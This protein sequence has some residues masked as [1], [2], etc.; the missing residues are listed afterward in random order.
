[1]ASTGS[2]PPKVPRDAVA[3][4]SPRPSLESTSKTRGSS[5]QGAI[6]Y[7]FVLLFSFFLL[8][9]PED[10][11]IPIRGIKF[12][13]IFGSA[14]I[15]TWALGAAS[16]QIKFRPSRELNLVLAL[17]AWLILGV[18]F[19]YWPSN[20]LSLLINDWVKI[21]MIFVVLTQTVTSTKRLRQ[22]LWLMFICGLLATG[23]ALV[24][25]NANVDPDAEARFLG[26]SRGFFR[27]NYLGIAA[28]AMIP[29][30]VAMFI[31]TRSFMKHVLII[32]CFATMVLMIVLTASRSNLVTVVVSLLL[33]WVIMLRDSMK[34]KLI[35][36]C[37]AVGLALA[38]ASAPSAFWERVGTLWGSEASATSTNG[39]SAMESEMQ[40]RAQLNAS[41]VAT[42]KY[43]IFGLGLNNFPVYSG[44]AEGATGITLGTHNTYTQV[45]SEGGIPALVMFLM[46]LTTG[47][48]RMRRIVRGC[49]DR[50]D[51]AE[52]K[53]FANAT[54]VS[55]VCFMIGGLFAHLAWEHYVYYLA[56]IG[57]ALQTIYTTRTG[58]SLAATASVE[59][60]WNGNG[61]AKKNGNG[62]LR[63]RHSLRGTRA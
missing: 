48:T 63:F 6:P 8:A 10:F 28:G 51:L 36:V 50:S 20:S 26:L 35:G 21:V 49:K 18:P 39:V 27:G 31:H 37:F 56:C 57:V 45:S 22:L 4:P 46:L 12:S 54:I 23:A 58:Q 59:E 1:M 5:E 24:T 47:I 44:T 9:R 53:A 40:R 34:A 13:M 7:Y 17:T 14:A 16:G 38:V 60:K 55:L 25:G 33:V 41:I 62:L 43:P 19:A 15:F 61:G 30:M 29:Y 3:L 2:L 42:A 52:E 32:S 11:V